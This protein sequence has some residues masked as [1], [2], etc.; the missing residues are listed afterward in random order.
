MKKVM[1]SF[2]IC[3]LLSNCTKKETKNIV[4]NNPYIISEENSK[5]LEDIKKNKIPPPP[6]IPG[7]LTYGTNTFLIDKDSKIYY[8]QRDKI[9]FICATGSENDT[10]PHLIDL[11][12]KDLIEIPNNCIG[13]FV[14]LNLKKEDRNL[15]FVS[16]QLDT[17]KT[18]NYFDLINAIKTSCQDRDIYYIGKTTQEEDT[19]LQYKKKNNSYNSNFI[20]WDRSRIKLAEQEKYT[21]S[22]KKEQ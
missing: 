8:F 13:D 22:T 12:P 19:V 2:V 20:E 1:V 7:W 5:T 4:K 16:S 6:P 11:Q 14:S 9:G 17:L 21:K 3:F 10:I 15:T 18:K